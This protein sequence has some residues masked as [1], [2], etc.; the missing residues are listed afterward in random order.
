MPEL[1]KNGINGYLIERTPE[2]LAAGLAELRDNLPL[3]QAMRTHIREDILAW[4]WSIKAQNFER[5]INEQLVQR[6]WT[7]SS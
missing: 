5:M 6:G 7:P 4:D 1:I 2:A 3:L